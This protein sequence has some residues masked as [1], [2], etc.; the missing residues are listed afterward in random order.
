MHTTERLQRLRLT[1]EDLVALWAPYEATV[2][3]ILIW[4]VSEHHARRVGVDFPATD[5][6]TR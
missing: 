2:K 1:G 4:D 3:R 6:E 5:L